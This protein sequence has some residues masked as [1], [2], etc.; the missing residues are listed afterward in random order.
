MRDAMKVLLGFS[1]IWG[2]FTLFGVLFSAL[3]WGENLPAATW[4]VLLLYAL[5]FLPLSL[6]AIRHPKA[7]AYSFYFLSVIAI[8][9]V[10]DAY[11]RS[12]H[13]DLSSYTSTGDHIFEV[14]FAGI[15]AL[16]GTVLLR[17]GERP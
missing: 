17:L 16:V 1:C 4:I 2:V 7:A 10:A 15:P 8:A 12:N 11:I 6:L 9:G 3:T 14:V 5:T 13:P